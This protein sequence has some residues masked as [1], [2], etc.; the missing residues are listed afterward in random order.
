M[1]INILTKRK[2]PTGRFSMFCF[3][4]AAIM[5]GALLVVLLIG[6][7]SDLGLHPEKWDVK[8]CLDYGMNHFLPPDMRDADVAITYSGYGYT[9][10]ENYTWYFFLAGKVAKIFRALS[11]SIAYYRIPNILLFVFMAVFFVKNIRRK[12]WLFVA[13]GICVQAWYI[14]SYTTADA[15]DFVWSFLAVNLL[16]DKDSMLFR[17]ADA[18]RITRKNW[19]CFVLPGL[20]FGMIILGKQN[21]WSILGLAFFVLLYRLLKQR[22]KKMQLRTLKNY[23]CI[24]AVFFAVLLFRASF[25]LIH[26]GLEKSEVK[27][28]MAIQYAHEDKNPATPLEEQCVSWHMFE[29]GVTIPEFFELQP[30]WFP[31]TWRSLCSITPYRD[32]PSWYYWTMGLLYLLICLGIACSSLSDKPGFWGKMEFFTGSALMLGGLIA[33]LVNS[34]VIDSQPQGRYL[35]PIFLIAGYLAS[36]TPKLFE[37]RVYRVLLVITGVLSVACFGLVGVPTFL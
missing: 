5:A 10:L 1:K 24:L 16:A 19:H 2:N 33:S 18:E 13:F 30:N 11:D 21:Y 8:A 27:E 20:L 22:D 6:L 12:N 7:F 32:C 26:Y 9:K 37:S 34:Y 14:F 36:R 35:L 15:L 23:C 4:G 31:M 28:V 3:F 17:A 29:R 25:D